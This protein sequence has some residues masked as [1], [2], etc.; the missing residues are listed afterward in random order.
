MSNFP[1]SFEQTLA[2][3]KALGIPS[4][5]QPSTPLEMQWAALHRAADAVAKLANETAA[6]DETDS[7]LSATPPPALRQLDQRRRRM[8]E[9]GLADLVAIMEPGLTALLA[10]HRSGGDVTTPA[11]ALWREFLAARSGLEALARA[12]SFRIEG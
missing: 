6:I 12:G 9:E 1:P 10:I 11:S 4:Q 3:G 2:D 7:L 8:I 5:N